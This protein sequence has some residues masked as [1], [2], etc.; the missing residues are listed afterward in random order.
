M[1]AGGSGTPASLTYNSVDS[2]ADTVTATG[3]YAGS[4]A[5]PGLAMVQFSNVNEITT[6]ASQSPGDE[7]TV[8]LP[9]SSS[10]DTANL[11]SVGKGT[12]DINFTGSL[13]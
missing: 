5:S 8:N 13:A 9:D 10:L 11:L 12:A 4:I 2:L 3:A 7:L 6:N 1:V